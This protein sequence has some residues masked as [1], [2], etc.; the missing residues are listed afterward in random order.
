[1]SKLSDARFEACAKAVTKNTVE[2]YVA[3]ERAKILGEF[4]T[5]KRTP[6]ATLDT[7]LKI[8]AAQPDTLA[9]LDAKHME[10][11]RVAAD[12]YFDRNKFGLEQ[13]TAAW[14]EPKDRIRSIVDKAIA[15]P[16]NAEQL[17]AYLRKHLWPEDV[18]HAVAIMK[19][20]E[21][22]LS[23]HKLC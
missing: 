17:G 18:E 7:C 6:K 10:S 21:P 2:S 15:S 13:P 3:A 12:D 4:L 11:L 14:G 8:A 16:M 22:Y 1:I 5:D 23:I 9:H 20:R 19:A